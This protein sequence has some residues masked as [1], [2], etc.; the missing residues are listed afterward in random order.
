MTNLLEVGFVV[1]FCA[2]FAVLSLTLFLY[3]RRLVSFLWLAAF[4]GLFA[5]VQLLLGERTGRD[6][7]LEDRALVLALVPLL[8]LLARGF[9]HTLLGAS[10]AWADRAFWIVGAGV[11]LVALLRPEWVV[12]G[13]LLNLFGVAVLTDI[14]I[15]LG[16][17][18]WRGAREAQIVGVGLAAFAI[19]GLFDIGARA[20]G[21]GFT[22]VLPAG[23]IVMFV[24]ISISLGKHLAS[25]ES[26]LAQTAAK[27]AELDA[28]GRMQ[29]QMLPSVLPEIDG[30]DVAA[31][32]T[33]ASE[34]GGDYYDV[35]TLDEGDF[36]ICGDATGHGLS[37]GIMVTAA[38]SSL[39]ST[40]FAGDPASV[41]GNM[42]R[43]LKRL[44]LARMAFAAAVVRLLDEELELTS[45]G[46]PPMLVAR[47]GT[48]SVD[49]V[50]ISAPPL[51]GALPGTYSATRVPFGPGDVALLTT[52]GLPEAMNPDGDEF[53]YER[54]RRRF[55]ELSTDGVDR[56]VGGLLSEATS[57][58]NGNDAD[59]DM[60][61]VAIRRSPP[62]G[63]S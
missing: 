48:G 12:H 3:R 20:A 35:L 16:V 14:L 15:T 30:F 2:A 58:L 4:A 21:L 47:R 59:D 9:V 46:M 28:A 25:V 51:G 57:W 60:T 26:E 63:R 45:A 32:S 37:A 8:V 54:L 22:P 56:V 49:E 62:P 55:L 42:D 36:V 5:C 23:L 19:A 52:D 24:S 7:V 27:T 34:V 11:T 29:A 31:S 41:L 10:R 44:G 40:S 61:F 38:K 13:Q 17:A 33:P 39:L 18:S 43:A 1:G 53:G 6:A 50:L